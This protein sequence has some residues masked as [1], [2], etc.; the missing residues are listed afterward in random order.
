VTLQNVLA[1]G[2]TD[3]V[4][5]KLIDLSGAEKTTI[6]LETGAA[7]PRIGSLAY[8]PGT[9]EFAFTELSRKVIVV[10]DRA[11]RKQRECKPPDVLALPPYAAGITYDPIQ[12]TFLTVFEPEATGDDVLVRELQVAGLCVPTG[13]SISLKSCGEGFTSPG[14]F[15]GIEIAGNTLLVAVQSRAICQVLI[16]PFG[17]SYKRGDFNRD[18]AVNLT[19]AVGSASYLF[20]SG[21]APLCADAADANDDGVL[22]VSDPVYLLFHL[23]LQGPPPLPPFPDAGTDPTF[24][25]N[26]GCEE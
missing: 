11:G 18:E 20:Q 25:D 1:V 10:T 19:D 21:P 22:D 24:R 7:E 9:E 8:I 13:F 17:P 16:F 23:F 15:G 3:G 5:V 2:R 12:N 6:S 14:F 4:L 26:I